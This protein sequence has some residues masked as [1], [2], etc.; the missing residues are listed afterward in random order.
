[1]RPSSHPRR[2]ALI[3]A[4]DGDSFRRGRRT[5]DTGCVNQPAEESKTSTF[6]KDQVAAWGATVLVGV[7]TAFV[8]SRFLNRR[9]AALITP[10]V[11]VVA[12]QQLDQRVATQIRKAWK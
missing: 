7:V 8:L 11:V 1:M 2:V 12:H 4:T 5:R 6:M 10:I 9:V 3:V